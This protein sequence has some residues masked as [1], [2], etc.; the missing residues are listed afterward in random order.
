MI[1]YLI[2]VFLFKGSGSVYPLQDVSNHSYEVESEYTGKNFYVLF[3]CFLNVANFK[4]M[5]I[6]FKIGN[7]HYCDRV[8]KKDEYM[9]CKF[10]FDIEL[11][12]TLNKVSSLENILKLA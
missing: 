12:S 8:C 11:H 7:R 4:L 9:V 1:K 2:L 10:K 5:F 6:I 3:K